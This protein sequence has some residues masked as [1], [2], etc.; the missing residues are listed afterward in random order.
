MSNPI[1]NSS[2]YRIKQVLHQSENM[3][4]IG[5]NHAVGLP[6]SQPSSTISGVA[7]VLCQ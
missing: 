2:S 4:D 6:T 3:D 1:S 5:N 7:D